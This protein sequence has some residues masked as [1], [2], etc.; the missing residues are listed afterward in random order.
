ML[1]CGTSV[2]RALVS[3]R[4]LECLDEAVAGEREGIQ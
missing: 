4:A 1:A 3:F 2:E